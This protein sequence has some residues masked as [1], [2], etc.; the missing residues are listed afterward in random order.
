MANKP[1]RKKGPKIKRHCPFCRHDWQGSPLSKRCPNCDRH[2]GVAT[3]SEL[4]AAEQQIQVKAPD[5]TPDA[6]AKDSGPDGSKKG[7]SVVVEQPEKKLPEVSEPVTE[8]DVAEFGKK[9]AQVK[10]FQI[11]VEML[12]GIWKA[13]FNV[14]AGAQ[15]NEAWKLE[16]DEADN[17]AEV[18]KPVVEKYAPDLLKEHMELAVLGA[19][20]VTTLVNKAQLAAEMAKKG[21]NENVGSGST[22]GNPGTGSPSVTP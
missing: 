17:L 7:L 16:K 21:G 10:D 20:L 5:G 3:K 19:V 9:T 13:G 1:G 11:R 4:A 8:E 6:E 12:A 14:L 22:A 18:S 2:I 15:K